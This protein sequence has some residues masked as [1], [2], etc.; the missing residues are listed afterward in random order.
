MP[1]SFEFD[2]RSIA[3][4][5]DRAIQGL[6]RR[7]ER[8]LKSVADVVKSASEQRAPVG[9]TGRLKRGFKITQQ[10]RFDG[11]ECTVVNTVP[12]A[13]FVEFGTSRTR[14]QPFMRPAIAQARSRAEPI[15]R[16]N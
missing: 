4:N 1:A 5:L 9:E 3:Q 10:A 2:A 11:F 16:R 6:K 8:N 13:G 14:P 7:S 15:L 12:Y